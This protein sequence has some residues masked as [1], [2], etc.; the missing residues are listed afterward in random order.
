VQVLADPVVTANWL[1]L[2]LASKAATRILVYSYGKGGKPVLRIEMGIEG[3]YNP[4]VRFDGPLLTIAD[5]L[6]HLR[7]YELTYGEQIREL[8]I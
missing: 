4:S 3:K 7:A 5:D 1:A 2:C 6:G 8:N